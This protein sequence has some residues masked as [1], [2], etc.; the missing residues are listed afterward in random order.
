[1]ILNEISNK[2]W[3]SV[4]MF[5]VIYNSLPASPPRI[6]D[7]N[8]V[9]IGINPAWISDRMPSQVWSEITDPF[10]NFNPIPRFIMDIISYPCRD[11]S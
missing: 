11:S 6:A 5:P 2:S 8:L 1:M 7:N 3:Q 4:Q 10:P 9:V